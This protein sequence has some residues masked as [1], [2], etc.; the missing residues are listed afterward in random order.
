LEIVTVS[1]TEII[2]QCHAI[3]NLPQ[4]FKWYKD[5]HLVYFHNV[6]SCDTTKIVYEK[7][8]IIIEKTNYSRACKMMLMLKNYNP[9]FDIGLYTCEVTDGTYPIPKNSTYVHFIPSSPEFYISP[10]I[11]LL[12]K[13]ANLSLWCSTRKSWNGGSNFAV[14]WK[15]LP[16]SAYSYSIAHYRYWN[17]SRINLYNITVSKGGT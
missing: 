14:S 2:L 5:R 1:D 8:T 11:S 4:L 13:T 9:V 3:G 17:G 10:N 12:A 7:V 16:V 15:V 6:T